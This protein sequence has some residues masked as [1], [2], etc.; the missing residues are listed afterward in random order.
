MGEHGVS[1]VAN[2]RQ[3]LGMEVMQ[4]GVRI[5]LADEPHGMWVPTATKQGHGP[6]CMKAAGIHIVG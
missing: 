2:Q 1:K 5:P 3:C 6:T 4:H